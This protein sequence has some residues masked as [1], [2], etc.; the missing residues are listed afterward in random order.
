MELVVIV[1]GGGSKTDLFYLNNE[2]IARLGIRKMNYKIIPLNVGNF[3]ALPKQV[4]M[5]RMYREI[6]YEAPCIMWY[7]QGT[8][9]NII[10][11]L[12][13]PDPE[14]CLENRDIVI[15]RTEGQEPENA[16]RSAGLSPEDVKTVIM[17]HLHWDHAQGFHIFKDAKFL[18]QR[19]EIE[20]ATAPLPCHH[21]LYYEKN[22]GKPQF[23]DYLDRIK[24]IDGD[25]QV[26]E[27]VN[28]VYIPSHTPESQGVLVRTEKGSYFIAGDA[29]GLFES[30]ETIPHVPSGI[31]N[32]LEQYYESMEKIERIADF[33]L[34]G[35]DMKIF[36]NSIYP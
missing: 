11:D 29:V 32:N 17:T 7:I 10:V 26:E 33:V 2:A 34:P 21:Y 22:T 23:V 31:F 6:T 20:Y 18:I 27:G 3:E 8:K 14:Q 4:C 1:R 16:L 36:D 30:W 19:K 12:G 28:C 15:N 9:H 5:Y 24:I 13:P 35:H 25:Y